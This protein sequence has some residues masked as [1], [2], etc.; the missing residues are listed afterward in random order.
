MYTVD[1][2]AHSVDLLTPPK[3]VGTVVIGEEIVIISED[4][5]FRR[6]L[7]EDLKDGLIPFSGEGRLFPRDGQK[8]IDRL[9]TRYSGSHFWAHLRK[10][11]E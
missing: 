8:F 7:G 10:E 2:F 1:F 5:A 6:F 11:G 9:L 4:K 3:M